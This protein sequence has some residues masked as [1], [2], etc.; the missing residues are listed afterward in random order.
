MSF[1]SSVHRSTSRFHSFLLEY[2]EVACLADPY[3]VASRKSEYHG[4]AED[5]QSCV[6]PSGSRR[7]FS[8]G[9]SIR[10]SSDNTLA[11]IRVYGVC[12]AISVFAGARNHRNR[13]AS[14]SWSRLSDRRRT[15]PL[16]SQKPSTSFNR[17]EFGGK[18]RENFVRKWESD[19]ISGT[20][21]R[22]DKACGGL[23]HRLRSRCPELWWCL[24]AFS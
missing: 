6:H 5:F 7:C 24:T 22:L 9:F 10:A 17:W 13:L 11:V 21:R 23:R 12:S 19:G 16:L 2:G 3:L 1:V 4:G 15:C 18:G 20:R 14:P 8:S